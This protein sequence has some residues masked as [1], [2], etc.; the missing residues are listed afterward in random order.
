MAIL[1]SVVDVNNGNTG[2]TKTDV[3][4]ALETVFANLGWNN[5]TAASGV[6]CMVKA[7]GWTNTQYTEGTENQ[8]IN[9][10]NNHLDDW[11]RAG[12]SAPSYQN[13]KNRYFIVTNNSTSA[14]RMLEEWRINGTTVDDAADT[15]YMLRHGIQTGDAL[16]YA[17]GISS[18]DA[19]K[20]IGG[21]SADTIYYAIRVDDNN[22]KVA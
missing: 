2:W 20:V 19:N 4:D 11:E 3:V 10:G 18:P 6:P 5:G 7:P 16:H 14:Y 12:G 17:A 1:K 22:F 21:L 13:Y 9:G 8:W 15:V